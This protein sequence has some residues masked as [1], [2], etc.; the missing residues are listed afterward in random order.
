MSLMRVG[1]DTGGTF[2][3]LVAWDGARI[4]TRKVRSTPDDP[5]RAIFEALEGLAAEEIVHGSTVATNAL[6]ERKGA[7][8]AFVTTAGFEDMLTMA[9]QHRKHLYDLLGP[10]RAELVPRRWTRGVAE[11]TFH[12]GS[13]ERAVDPAEVGRLGEDLRRQGV[14]SV[15]VCLLHSYANPANEL[16]VA[17]ALEGLAVSLSHQVLPEYREYERASTTVINAYVT[18]LM[19]RYLGRLQAGL[20]SS[21]LRIMQSNGGQIPVEMAAR[22]AI[23]TIQSGPAGGV[24]G[25]VAAAR[26]AGFDRVITFDMGGTSTD[27]C[28]YDGRYSFTQESEL[29]DFPVRVPILDIHSVGAGGGSIARVDAGGA[30]RVGP[31]SAGARPGPVCYGEGE[32]ITITD[33]NLYLG[34]IDPERFLSG[35]MRLDTTR[36]GRYLEK[37]AG[38]HGA[39]A[40]EM[41]EAIVRVANSNMQRAIRAV[42]IERGYD[43]RQFA[44]VS[45]GGAGGLHA[46]ELADRLEISTVLVPVHAGVLSALGMLVADCVRDYSRSVLGR[47]V[48]PAFAEMEQQAAAELAEMGFAAPAVER[49]LDL[50]YRGQSYEITVPHGD[51][52]GFDR[53][54]ERLYGYSHPGREVEAVTARVRAT[55]ITDKIDLGAPSG[56]ESFSSTYV[57]AGWRA[58]A[59]GSGNVILRKETHG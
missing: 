44:L 46:C 40:R 38:A 47:P 24:L 42:S 27:V 26:R 50:R 55:G 45:F 8:T 23:H 39:G 12:D 41:A 16:A 9:R 3:D 11:R 7:R 18:P 15:A 25:A 58:E 51:R 33:A 6:L 14:E 1:I 35:R 56:H 31:E 22:S 59:D 2:T 52:A 19:A 32:Q 10:G 20:G 49:A 57:P 13:I 36:A 43:P 4:S 30:L 17:Q 37:F 53:E 21:R 34:R 28:L 5:S 48:E 54:H 29:G